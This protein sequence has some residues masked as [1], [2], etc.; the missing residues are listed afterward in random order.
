M[1]N[2]PKN[3]EIV[4]CAP[5]HAD[6][7]AGMHENCFETSWGTPSF[8]DLFSMPGSYGFIALIEDD[9]AGFIVARHTQEEGEIITL[10]VLPNHRRQGLAQTLIR[11]AESHLKS[12]GGKMMFLEV[13]ANNQAAKSLYE[14]LGYQEV[15]RREQ[16]YKTE[17]GLI[18][19]LI[20]KITF[21]ASN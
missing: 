21:T 10:G 3:V 11:L 2:T 19:A 1:M 16:Y 7:L 20:L 8:I 4:M 12:A 6:V 14:Q 17:N 13:A 9:P 5:A 15:G 18:D